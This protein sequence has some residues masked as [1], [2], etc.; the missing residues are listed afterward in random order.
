MTKIKCENSRL[1]S[2]IFAKFAPK[3]GLP[4][5]LVVLCNYFNN[6]LLIYTIFSIKMCIIK[7]T[8]NL[9]LLYE[10]IIIQFIFLSK[11]GRTVLQRNYM[12]Y[13]TSLTTQL[14]TIRNKFHYIRFL[15]IL[16][17][18]MALNHNN[19]GIALKEIFWTYFIYE[20]I[21]NL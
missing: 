18:Y 19:H 16:K 8:T 6:Y 21:R 9:Y 13:T 11:K 7:F 12:F 4:F 2:E 5:F 3:T 10:K 1:Y 15:Y 17:I 20:L 14:K